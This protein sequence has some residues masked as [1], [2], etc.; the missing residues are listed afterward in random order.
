[1]HVVDAKPATVGVQARQWQVMQVRS[2]TAGSRVLAQRGGAEL[3]LDRPGLPRAPP[4]HA[5]DAR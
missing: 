5:L 2:A 3:E 1:M 4:A